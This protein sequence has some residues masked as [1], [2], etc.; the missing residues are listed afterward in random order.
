MKDKI[1]QTCFESKPLSLFD[2]TKTGNLRSGCNDCKKDYQLIY[3]AK[4]REVN[5]EMIKTRDAKRDRRKDKSRIS[6]TKQ[7]L[8]MCNKRGCY[9]KHIEFMGITGYCKSHAFDKLNE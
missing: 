2:F 5:K 8:D 1:C 9:D 4:Y 6:T 7:T 3:Q